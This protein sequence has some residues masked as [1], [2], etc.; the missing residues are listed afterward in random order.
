MSP[1]PLDTVSIH[2]DSTHLT[3][4]FSSEGEQWEEE[5][6]RLPT[7]TDSQIE[8]W[9]AEDQNL[10]QNGQASTDNFG[11]NDYF[12]SDGEQW[13]EEGQ[14]VQS[15]TDSQREAWR[16]EARIANAAYNNDKDFFDQ[17]S[18]EGD[19]L[20]EA[21]NEG[22]DNENNVDQD[23]YEPIV[24]PMRRTRVVENLSNITV[25]RSLRASRT[26][27]TLRA[28]RRTS[29][30]Q[31]CP[32]HDCRLSRQVLRGRTTD[33][34]TDSEAE[35]LERRFSHYREQL[36]PLG[37]DSEDTSGSETSDSDN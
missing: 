37:S 8:A 35:H 9:R 11:Y 10:G 16:E 14:Q 12:I 22:G 5:G 13:E 3:L 28:S 25:H 30:M 32:C 1:P 26:T 33:E 7:P 19:S 29:G 31:P 21:N 34:Y 2:S 20:D 4:Q 18:E 17:S 23:D 15:P 6:Q 24:F 36:F 27:D